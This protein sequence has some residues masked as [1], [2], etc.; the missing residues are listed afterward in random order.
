MYILMGI[1]TILIGKY[2]STKVMMPKKEK[3]K[4]IDEKNYI[5]S[6]RMLL[7]C[8]GLYYLFFGIQLLFIKGW[9]GY[10]VIFAIMIP[11]LIVSVFS[12]NRRKYL[13]KI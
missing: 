4:V 9:P 2:L 8:L 7:Y 13:H 11:L 5:K 6:C 3:Y 1:C 12:S 10:I